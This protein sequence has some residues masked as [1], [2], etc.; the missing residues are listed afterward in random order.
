MTS[1]RPVPASPAVLFLSALCLIVPGLVTDL[2]GLGGA[3]LYG[4]QRLI[5]RRAV[6]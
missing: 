6:A 1:D 4:Y 2:I 3:I 5:V